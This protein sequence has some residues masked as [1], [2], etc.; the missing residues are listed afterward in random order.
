MTSV[1][2]AALV[3]L[4]IGTAAIAVALMMTRK[5]QSGV[6]QR[7]DLV[8]GPNGGKAIADTSLT[9]LSQ[10]TRN[11]NAFVLSIF[12]VGMRRRWGVE[13]GA[14]W[15]LL[16]SGV[17][18]ATLWIVMNIVLGT[19][20]WIALLPAVV[21]AFMVPRLL[22]QR[23][24]SRAE[25][26]FMDVFADAIDTAV[27]MMRAG[28]PIS[29]AIRFIGNTAP[30][31]LSTV[32]ATIADQTQMGVSLNQ[33]LEAASDQ[34]GLSDFRFF[35]VAIAMQQATGGNL[36]VTLESL[37]DII[38]KR[39][40]VRMKAKAASA[41]MRIAAYILGSMP[42]LMTGVLMIIQPGYLSPLIDDPRGHVVLGIAA[43]LLLLAFIT[44]RKMMRSVAN[45]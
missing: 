16:V 19:S 9:R 34:I 30:P 2:A 35:V 25:R 36:A 41:E 38:R 24:Q 37:A 10:R 14:I 22:I 11:A 15:L 32:F 33:A 20:A 12:A 40:A 45:V 18:A 26:Q 28:L 43:G 3:L 6:A 7:V 17:S 42:F 31:P 27:R 29:A 1:V 5:A 44:M 23:E 4:L 21:A 39:R 8:V 13:S